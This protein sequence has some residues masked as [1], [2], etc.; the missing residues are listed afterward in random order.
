MQVKN[1]ININTTALKNDLTKALDSVID[2][3][4]AG[5]TD[6]ALAKLKAMK[7]AVNKD[8]FP[9]VTVG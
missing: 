7:E 1:V 6:K 2:D 4:E 9:G 8:G 3:L 5:D